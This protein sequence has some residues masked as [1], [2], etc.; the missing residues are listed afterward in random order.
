MTLQ[1]A[2]YTID[3]ERGV[4]LRG[5]AVVPLSPRALDVLEMILT[6]HPA[7][8]ARDDVRR[9]LWAGTPVLDSSINM[10]IDELRSTLE[11]GNSGL[12]LVSTGE[13]LRVMERPVRLHVAPGDDGGPA[14]IWAKHRLPLPPGAS[15]LG[16]DS[17]ADI[18][19]E[20]PT[21][22]REHARVVID[23]SGQI[24]IQ[25]LDSKNG[26]FIGGQRLDETATPL[27]D[28]DL[29]RLGDVELKVQLPSIR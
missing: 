22:S 8:V 12:D 24:T 21:V 19:I 28:G 9:Q 5:D 18:V 20:A 1:F 29:V 7:P 16:R 13:Y 27:T 10:L 26:T 6:N 11:T 15:T 17:D 14:L 2:G 23:D 3:L 25:D 4:L